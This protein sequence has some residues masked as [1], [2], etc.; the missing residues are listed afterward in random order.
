M[1]KTVRVLCEDEG[2]RE[3]FIAG[4]DFKNTVVEFKAPRDI[5]GKFANVKITALTSV[6]EGELL[7]Q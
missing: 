6:L 4:R 5:I 7:N 2:R 1:G 3:G